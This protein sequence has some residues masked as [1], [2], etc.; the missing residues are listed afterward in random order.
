MERLLKIWVVVTS[1]VSSFPVCLMVQNSKKDYLEGHNAAR[2]RV[3]SKPLVW[4][5]KLESH[6][7]KFLKKH[8]KDCLKESPYLHHNPKY[9]GTT[10]YSS[11]K[12]FTGADAIARWVKMKENYDYESNSCIDGNPN[13]CGPYLYM[14]WSTVTSLGCARVECHNNKGTLVHCNYEPTP[15]IFVERPYP[16][17]YTIH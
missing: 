10:S 7:R 16:Y 17:P 5:K 2:A 15:K 6:A 8:A 3:G 1:L 14:V 11:T 9:A 12:S 13:N 4:D